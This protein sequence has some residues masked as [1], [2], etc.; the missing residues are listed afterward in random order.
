MRRDLDDPATIQRV[1]E[2]V[3]SVETLRLLAALDRSRLAR[4]RARGVGTGEG[5]AR[6]A[7]RRPGGASSMGGTELER[8]EVAEFPTAEQLTLLASSRHPDRTAEASCSRSSTDDRPGIFC[9]VAGVLALHGLDVVSAS[10]YSAD[11][12]ALSEFGVV[13]PF[14]AETPWPRIERDLRLALDGRLAV[15]ARVAERARTY[16]KPDQARG[17]APITDG[18]LRQRGVATRD[19]HR[20][21]RGRRRRRAVPHHARARASSTSTSVRRACRRSARKWSTRST[22]STTTGHKITDAETTAEI[23]RAI[24]HALSTE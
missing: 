18:A 8:I 22:S 16:A 20:R 7:A 24:I 17:A 3:S 6:R 5:A 23:E 15:Q 1:A 2:Q 21:A 14:R 4:D 12:R 10:A 19:R 13:G 11:G 9:K